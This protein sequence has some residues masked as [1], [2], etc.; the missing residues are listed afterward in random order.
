[1]NPTKV[2][3]L[4]MRNT[5]LIL[6]LLINFSIFGQD[7]FSY[8]ENGLTPKSLRFTIENGSTQNSFKQIL[9]WIDDNAKTFQLKVDKKIENEVLVFEST[10][11]NAVVYDKQYNHVKYSI[12]IRIDENE[13]IFEPISI[14]RK[15]NSKYDMGWKDVNLKDGGEYFKRGK[16]IRKYRKYVSDITKPLNLLFTQYQS[17]LS[18]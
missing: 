12:T 2:L 6:I 7:K 14:Q 3:N 15:V 13:L 9:S 18:K 10:K 4:K 5:F 1:M 16:V 17:H 8:T 11:N